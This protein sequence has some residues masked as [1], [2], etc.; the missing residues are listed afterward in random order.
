MRGHYSSAA[1]ARSDR[2]YGMKAITRVT[3]NVY[4]GR[5]AELQGN[6]D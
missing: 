3:L 2:L 4:N 5:H 1:G 6:F